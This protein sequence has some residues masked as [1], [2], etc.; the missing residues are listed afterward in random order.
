MRSR[1]RGTRRGRRGPTAAR[2]AAAVAALLLFLWPLGSDPRAGVVTL[3]ATRDNTLFQDAEGDT[4]NGVGPAFFAGNNGQDLVRR[5]VIAFDLAGALPAGV[6]IESVV[7]T[8]E[9]TS[10]PDTELRDFTLHRVLA[11]W[12]EGL[13]SSSGGGG[14][15]AKPGDATWLHTFHASAFWSLPGGDFAPAASA[16]LAIG[17]VGTATWSSPGMVS[18]VQ[19]WLAGDVPNFGWLIRGDEAHAR[20]VRRFDSRESATVANR[21]TLTI[22]F[23]APVPTRTTTWG[24]LKTRFR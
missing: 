3:P 6:A 10:A 22:T 4:S 11:D 20:S 18:D 14:A 24:E 5:A 19:A 21:P 13:S 1:D 16:S 8:L 15:P 7:L 23:S 9:V 2:L 12:G 17:D